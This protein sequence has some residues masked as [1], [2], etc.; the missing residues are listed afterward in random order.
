L[1]SPLPADFIVQ[2]YTDSGKASDRTRF[3][4]ALK[5]YYS[6]LEAQA[7][8]LAGYI[9]AWSAGKACQAMA[10]N[11]IDAALEFPVRVTSAAG[12]GQ[13]SETTVVVHN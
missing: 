6:N 10:A 1:P 8:R 4:S 2:L 11:A 9:Y 3:E 13:T 7:T 12:A 5:S